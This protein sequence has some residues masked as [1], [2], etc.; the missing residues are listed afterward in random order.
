MS[1]ME[2]TGWPL[3][4]RRA[5]LPF[6]ENSGLWPVTAALLGHVAIVLVLMILAAARME[7][8]LSVASVVL[9]IGASVWMGAQERRCVG[10]LGALSVAVSL[11]WAVALVGAWAADHYGAL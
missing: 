1:A 7:S 11:T 2:P 8:P 5:V 3:W 4:V 9:A 6:L 10:K